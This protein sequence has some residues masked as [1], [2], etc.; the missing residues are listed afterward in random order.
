MKVFN[1][2][3]KKLEYLYN[4]VISTVSALFFLFSMLFYAYY[5]IVDTTNLIVWYILN[6]SALFLRA[7]LFIKYKK[8]TVN[9]DN[10]AHFYWRFF[11]AMTLSAFFVGTGVF[12]I[13]PTEMD[14]QV[15]YSTLSRSNFRDN[16]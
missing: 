11:G 3:L 14:Y 10:F 13:F 2:E 8:V 9:E 15:I 4:G 12:Y 16:S 5:N 1:Q 6:I 7:M